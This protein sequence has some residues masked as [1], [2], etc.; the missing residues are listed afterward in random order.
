[1]LQNVASKQSSAQ[2]PKMSGLGLDVL[3][4][5]KFF[6]KTNKRISV[7]RSHLSAHSYITELFKITTVKRKTIESEGKFCYCRRGKVAVVGS[8]TVMR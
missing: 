2:R 4:E 1:M 6:N 5:N 7:T 8:K 3:F